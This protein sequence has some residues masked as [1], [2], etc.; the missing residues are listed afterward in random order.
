AHADNVAHLV[1]LLVGAAFG[2]A[3]K[4]AWWTRRRW[5][6]VRILFGL[7]GAAGTIGALVLILTRTPTTPEERAAADAA[8][9]STLLVS[10]YEK[11]CVAYYANDLPTAIG[12]ATALAQD[13]EIGNDTLDAKGVGIMCDG[14]L[15]MR[16]VCVTR[17][18]LD[19]EMR[20]SYESMCTK[21][22]PLFAKL[23]ARTPPS[24]APP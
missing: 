11:M 16:E 8:E 2:L 5:L 21:Y 10:H 15:E 22:A 7:I 13:F 20:E 9:T 17:D 12:A 24:A 3:V 19:R 1:G 18:K 14:V 23:P 4:P 6:P